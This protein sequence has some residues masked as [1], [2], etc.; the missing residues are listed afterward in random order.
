MTPRNKLENEYRKL[1]RK[2]TPEEKDALRATGFDP[3][4][5][6]DSGVPKAHRYLLLNS[7]NDSLDEDSNWLS[8][9]TQHQY[10]KFIHE[11][12]VEETEEK[13]FD[14]AQVLDVIRRIIS[15]LDDSNKPEVKMQGTMIL[16]ALGVP[17]QPSMTELARQYKVNRATIS[18]HVKRIQKKLNLPPSVY[19]KSEYACSKLSESRKRSIIK[20]ANSTH[21]YF[22]PPWDSQANGEQLYFA[23]DAPRYD[24]GRGSLV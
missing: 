2:A 21:W 9:M 11:K 14:E 4:D 23:R 19:M 1:W 3:K 8:Y 17:G 16:L 5:P 7:N 10:R 15:V 12:A 18:Y 22:A 20:N 6:L 13:F 24:W